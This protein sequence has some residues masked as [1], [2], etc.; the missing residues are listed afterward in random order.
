MDQRDNQRI[1]TDQHDNPGLVIA[2]QTKYWYMRLHIHTRDK[3]LWRSYV[4][5]LE[6]WDL[7]HFAILRFWPC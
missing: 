2:E 3:V 5:V 4:H 1:N 6:P 7:L